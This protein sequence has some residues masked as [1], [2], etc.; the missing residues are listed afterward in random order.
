MPPAPAAPTANAGVNVFKQ[1]LVLYSADPVLFVREVPGAEPDPAQ[2][3][4]LQAYAQGHRRIAVRSGHGIGK[5]TV[6]SWALI[7]HL[8]CRHPS[9]AVVTAPTTAQLFDA[10]FAEL[11]RWCDRLP[12]MLKELIEV[13]SERIELKA[14]PESAFISARTSRAEQPEALQGIHS[15]FVLLIADEASGI[16]ESV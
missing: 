1:F 12:P 13:K 2:A 14:T 8:L 3:A 4:I 16:P 6:A 9:K 11:K 15:E 5:S 10:L 7:H